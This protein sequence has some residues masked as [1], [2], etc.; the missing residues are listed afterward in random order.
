MDKQK[1]SMSNRDVQSCCIGITERCQGLSVLEWILHFRRSKDALLS[2][3]QGL[4]DREKLISSTAAPKAVG[5]PLGLHN[6]IFPQGIVLV[7][8]FPQLRACVGISGN[9]RFTWEAK[10]GGS[11]GKKEGLGISR[12]LFVVV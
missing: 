3:M 2:S 8:V 4:T 1:P 11:R 5:A 6:P 10:G 9:W 7:A 12:A